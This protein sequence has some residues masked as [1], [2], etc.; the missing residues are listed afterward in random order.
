MWS[1]WTVAIV[2]IAACAG[3]VVLV[4]PAIAH[5][6]PVWPYLA[7]V[8]LIYLGVLAVF[9]AAYF[10]IAWIYR[11]P[12]PP[13]ARIGPTETLRLVAGEYWTVAGDMFRIL[14]YRWWVPDPAPQ[15]ARLP[16]LL[17]HGVL[18]NAGVWST[19]VRW[20]RRAGI[21][22]VYAPSYGPPLGSID[23]FADQVHDCVERMCAETGAEQVFVATHSMGGLVALA[24]LR[25]H[26]ASRVRRLVAIAAPFR[27]SVLARCFFGTSLSQLRPDNAWLAALDVAA[28]RASPP[29]VSIWSRHDSMVAPQTSSE[30]PGAKNIALT[31]IGHNALLH[32]AGVF[33]LVLEEY[34]RAL[35]A[36]ATSVSPA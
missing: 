24:Y 32:D 4:A 22:S 23:L 7:A 35:Q 19:F 21:E 9:V 30:L 12:R 8:P 3:Y 14:L 15:P 27:G 13:H 31:G 36:C 6:A 10:V 25:R 18:C 5:G 28:P 2:L 16:V 34:R 26:G 33:D 17:V 1:A 29:I 11:A 20:L